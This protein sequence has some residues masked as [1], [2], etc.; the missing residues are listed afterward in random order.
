MDPGVRGADIPSTPETGPEPT[1]PPGDQSWVHL[2]WIG[3]VMGPKPPIL[4]VQNMT[5]LGVWNG[6]CF[7]PGDHE[8]GLFWW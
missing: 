8:Y 4:G 2:G 3:A 5:I 1:W 6:W 7:W